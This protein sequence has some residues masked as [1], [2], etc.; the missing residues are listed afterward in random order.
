M[1]D[2]TRP[3]D[4][5]FFEFLERLAQNNDR[6]W[7]A[8]HKAEYQRQCQ[9]PATALVERLVRPLAK[10]APMLKV[11]PRGHG[12]S[13]MRVYRDTRFSPDKTPY[14]THVGLA[15]DHAAG[16]DCQSV[17][18]AY[19]HLSPTESFV[20]VGCW[21][22]PKEPLAAIRASIDADPAA[23]KKATGGKRFRETFTLGGSSLKTAPRDYPKDHPMI[24]DLRRKDFVAISPVTTAQWIDN[25]AAE[26]IV[27]KIKAARPFAR[28][29]ADSVG[30]P[31]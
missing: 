28:W 1:S 2:K 22:P 13:V 6:D 9:A 20:A 18:G 27:E 7:F 15:L 14:K 19:V 10:V 29:L 12:G 23:W 16:G 26:L 24:V 25:D 5:A 4:A 17:P 8:E 11:D 3:I 30:V 21:Q 31:W